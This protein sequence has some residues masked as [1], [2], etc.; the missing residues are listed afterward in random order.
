MQPTFLPWIG[1]FDLIDQVDNFVFL[2][3]VQFSK[4]GWQQRNRIS[5]YRGLDWITM[6]V[7]SG[8]LNRLIM[9]VRIGGSHNPSKVINKI[10][11][12]YKSHPHFEKFWPKIKS[13]LLSYNNGD[14]LSEL[15]I[16]LI[17]SI[18]ETLGID[19]NFY[20]SSDINKST[21]KIERL[22]D[23][24][25]YLNS[26]NYLSPIGAFGYLLDGVNL[27]S[28]NNIN[29][30]FHKYNHPNYQD[31]RFPFNQGASV[32]DLLFTCGDKSLEIIRS[33][34]ENSLRMEELKH[35]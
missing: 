22:I 34:R 8:R 13:I 25:N 19:K 1:Y 21:D 16:N 2:D 30:K 4:Q 6:P 24:N 27:F 9:D 20:M 14:L 28:E 35:E 31:Q 5:T 26:K 7:K 10:E 18:T 33:G 29:I 15:N 3:N 32:I 17:K 23:I 11:E 12:T